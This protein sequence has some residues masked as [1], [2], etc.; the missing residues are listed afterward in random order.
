MMS[1]ETKLAISRLR[2]EGVGPSET[3]RR[4]DLPVSTVKRYIYTHIT[5]R[6]GR[7]QYCGKYIRIP[8]RPKPGNILCD[9]C[10]QR[11]GW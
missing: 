10:R 7:C 8:K 5:Q 11:Y 9:Y 3:A 4:L 2:S 6:E 1:K